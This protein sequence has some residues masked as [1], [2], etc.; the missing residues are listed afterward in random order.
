MEY[1]RIIK[2]LGLSQKEIAE[3]FGYKNYM[4]FMNSKDGRKKIENGIEKLYNHIL[5]RRQKNEI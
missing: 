4:S 2:E 1:K 5:E 3:F